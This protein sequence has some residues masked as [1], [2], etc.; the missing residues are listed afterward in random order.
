M[1]PPQSYIWSTQRRL[2]FW[3]VVFLLIQQGERL[4][5]LGRVV[6]QDPPSI[7][8]LAKTLVIGLLADAVTTFWAV[9][10]AMVLA[11]F[12]SLP[13]VHFNRNGKARFAFGY[14]RGLLFALTLVALGLFV[15]STVDIGYYRYN[16]QH[17]DFVFFEFV[18]ELLHSVPQE[19]PSQAAQQTSSELDKI[20]QWIIY[21]GE[22][23]LLEAFLLSMWCGRFLRGNAFRFP[24]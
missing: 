4:F 22:F 5:L 14:Y 20:R 18:D 23:V 15:V 16:H 24:H 7:G 2:V 17:V 13:F 10:I 6:L 19:T 21:V 1:V 8:L 12:F 11:L 3:G 9:A